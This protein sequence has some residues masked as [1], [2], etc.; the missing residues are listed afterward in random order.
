MA[1]IAENTFANGEELALALA[2]HVAFR[3]STAVSEHR[4]ATLAVSGGSTPRR[5]FEVLSQQEID[6]QAVNILL[7]DE[8]DVPPDHERSNARLVRDHLLR[9]A[10]AAAT[11]LPLRPE[12]RLSELEARLQALHLPP[13][14]C[15]LGMGS[16]G[17]TASWF[18]GGNNLQ[19]ATNP[20]G[21][22][23]VM[24]MEA[25][26]A[27]EKRFTLTLPAIATSPFLVLHIEGAEKLAVLKKAK[28]EGPADEL[29]IRHLLR[30][31][32][33]RLNL[34]FAP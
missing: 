31:P 20:A 23:L 6:W 8:R 22:D 30:L 16:D 4:S 21:Q 19:A 29:P 34:Y 25:P 27:G 10:A 9:G 5:L 18:P 15:L 28:A 33:A 17:H 32:D 7:V 11:L 26:A 13:D 3:L 12:G 14:I 1:L 24:A 2:R